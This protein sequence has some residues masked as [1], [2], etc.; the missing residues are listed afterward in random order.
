MKHLFF[1]ANEKKSSPEFF[2]GFVEEEK[3]RFKG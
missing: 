1:P 2:P 3:N